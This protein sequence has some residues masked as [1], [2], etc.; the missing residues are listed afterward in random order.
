MNIPGVPHLEIPDFRGQIDFFA[1]TSRTRLSIL[2][3]MLVVIVGM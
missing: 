3:L 2:E 1:Y